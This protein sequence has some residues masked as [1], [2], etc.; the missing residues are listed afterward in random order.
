MGITYFEKER[1][2]KLD[3]PNTSYC[4]GIVDEEGFLGHAYYGRKIDSIQ[5]IDEL[6][7]IYEHPSVPSKNDRD[8]LSFLDCFPTEYSSHGVGDYRE[9][10]ARVK[11]LKGH[12]AV[13]F[14]YK[15]HTIFQG[16][17]KLEGLPASFGSDEE[18]TTLEITM[19]DPVLDLLL[20]LSYSVFTDTDVIARSARFI[21]QGKDPIRLEKAMSMCMDMENRDFDMITMHG[22][23][24]RERRMDRRRITHGKHSVSSLRGESGHQEHPFMAILEHDASQIRGEVYGFS[25]MYSGNFRMMAE[26]N[27]FNSVRMTVGIEPEDFSW[28]LKQGESFQCPEVLLTFSAEGLGGMT[29]AFHK[30]FMNH[31]IRSPY[32]HQ[33]RPILINNWEATYFDF[34]EEK[35][36]NIAKEASKQGIEMLVMDDGWFGNRFDDNRAL[37]DWEVNE[38]KLK[39]GLASLV[40]KVNALS[41]DFG[42]WFEPEMISPESELYKAHPDWAIQIP[43]RRS[44][45]ARN[46]FVLDI[47]RKEVRDHILDQMFKVL[48][49]A[50]IKYVKW[51]MNRPL[52]DLGSACLDAESQGELYHRYVLGMYEMQERLLK[53]FPNLLLENCSGGGA[54]FDGGMLYYSPQIWCSD[55]TDAIERLRIQESTSMIYPL[56]TMG[57]HVSVC[58]NHSVGRN[59]PF[60]TRG[61]VALAGTFGYELDITAISE[62]ERNMIKK[63]TQMYHRFAE[64]VREGEYYRIASY[65]ENLLYDCFQVVSKDRK[66]TLVFYVQAIAEVSAK[67][68]VVRLQGLR[69][70]VMYRVYTC[71]ME[72]GTELLKACNRSFGGD[73]L[74]NAGMKIERQWGDFRGQILYLKN[75]D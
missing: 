58:P 10:S 56:S 12:S 69:G 25:F 31:V 45:R 67:N 75:E 3:T 15:S 2:F 27:Q 8:R 62:Q 4:M 43:G 60:D 7:G 65:Q 37:G 53:E 57:S 41:M 13:S 20:V 52:S 54:R 63:Q 38:D 74:M 70:D 50:N 73:L 61:Y 34:D 48:H 17:K 14:F 46:Q 55:D 68:R 39:G 5:G 71:D 21:N 26:C 23:W 33:N 59:T 42:I 64:L 19:E 32:K 1:I 36:L 35:L 28:N 24:A 6:M 72:E 47:S 49:S 29:R 40:E 22:C 16:K 51:D 30:V 66:E 9:S 11:T 18:V 44:G